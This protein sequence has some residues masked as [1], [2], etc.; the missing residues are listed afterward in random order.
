MQGCVRCGADTRTASRANR[1]PCNTGGCAAH[2][3]LSG[4]SLCGYLHRE[5]PSPGAGNL[6][7]AMRGRLCDLVW[8]CAECAP[9]GS[10]AAAAG[11]H[12]G[13][14]GG[15]VGC[16]GLQKLV[17]AMRQPTVQPSRPHSPH[18]CR[19]SS[20]VRSRHVLSTS[21]WVWHIYECTPTRACFLV[22]THI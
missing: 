15:T 20:T 19:Q 8:A 7:R 9:S 14:T 16:N 13:P 22:P 11:L 6:G 17:C 21:V 3:R 4:S 10:A 18:T 1:G 5:P 2:I 12:G